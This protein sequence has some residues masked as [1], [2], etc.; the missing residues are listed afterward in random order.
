MPRSRTGSYNR[1]LEED[2]EPYKNRETLYFLFAVLQALGFICIILVCIWTDKYMGG[3]AWDGSGK[4][5]NWHP[6]C[7][8]AGFIY[9]YGNGK[10]LSD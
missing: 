6:V 8:V 7:M 3:F 9:F 5:F 2:E 1:D 10:G 4:M